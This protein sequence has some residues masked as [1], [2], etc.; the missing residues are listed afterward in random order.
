[1]L[2]DHESEQLTR[3]LRR[4]KGQIEG[5]EKMVQDKRYCVDTMQQI[6]AARAALYQ[7]GML[8]LESHSR[9]CV[10]DA[11]QSGHE[12]QAMTEL[13]GVFKALHK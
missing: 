8:L 6:A 1:M 7:V 5:I 13:M 12:E 11:V 10:V 9:S 3:R 4:I 2:T